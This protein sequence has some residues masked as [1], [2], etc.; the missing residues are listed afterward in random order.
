[1]KTVKSILF[2]TRPGDRSELAFKNAMKLAQAQDADVHILV[3]YPDDVE[4]AETVGFEEF[5]KLIEA[6]TQEKAE[7]LMALVPA[8]VPK[9]RVTTRT[10]KQYYQA[11]LLV[12]SERHD[13]VIK[14]PEPDV[15]FIEKVLGS[16]DMHLLRKCPCPVW[17][18]RP[19][20]VMP[21]KRLLACVAMDER[22]GADLR[23]NSRVIEM[24][25]ELLDRS[26]DAEL[27]IL[28]LWNA[29]GEH[30]VRSART[31][32]SERQVQDWISAIREKHKSWFKDLVQ[33]F[34][35]RARIITHFEKGFPEGRIAELAEKLKASS[36]VMGT[37][38]RTGISGL[39]MGNTAETVL[40][41][42][43]GSV[44]A[45]KPE[46]FSTPIRATGNSGAE[47]T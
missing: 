28:H 9:P 24:G 12:Q 14:A 18:M 40:H 5:N 38:G 46:K 27:H 7:E 1:M 42:L 37:V 22:E 31:G 29:P 6:A 13:L 11:I 33:P 25:L 19:E 10:G 41:Q 30:L 16:E 45:L 17:L 34:S 26:A 39:F 43:K 8:G 35:G 44:L 47:T 36:V 23:L 15:G 3:T 2:V 4:T 21:P 32:L 20:M